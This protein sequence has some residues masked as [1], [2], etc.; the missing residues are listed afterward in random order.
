MS[1]TTYLGQKGYTLLKTEIPIEMQKKIQKD[2][3]IQPY[4]HGQPKNSM[5]TTF[6]AYREIGRVHV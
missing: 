6:P 4:V 5:Q 2:L 3:L 1:Y